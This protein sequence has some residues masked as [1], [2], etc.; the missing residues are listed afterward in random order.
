MTKYEFVKTNCELER[1]QQGSWQISMLPLV[2]KTACVACVEGND[3]EDCILAMIDRL[4]EI[5]ERGGLTYAESITRQILE[6]EGWGEMDYDE[7]EF[8][9][10]T[11]KGILGICLMDCGLMDEI[12]DPRLDTVYENFVDTMIKHGYMMEDG[13][14]DRH[15]CRC[16]C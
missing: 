11:P 6:H 3:E 14:C 7:E 5:Y 2:G 1:D 13:A 8:L 15:G 12:N 4:D 16:Q 10:L 9:V